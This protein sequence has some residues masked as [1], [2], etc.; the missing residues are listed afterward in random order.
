MYISIFSLQGLLY[1]CNTQGLT[2]WNETCPLGMILCSMCLYSGAFVF[3]LYRH[4]AF[5]WAF[6][7]LHSTLLCIWPLAAVAL[8]LHWHY[9][10]DHKWLFSFRKWLS[11]H[12]FRPPVV[13]HHSFGVFLPTICRIVHV[14]VHWA[15][16][17]WN[18]KAPLVVFLTYNIYS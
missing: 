5:D 6:H 15:S 9:H 16:N 2:V 10:I 7:T 1:I 18:I 3:V 12:N 11:A 17:V 14:P 8:L 4:A 13:L